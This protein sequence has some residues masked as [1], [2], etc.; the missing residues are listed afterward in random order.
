V[1]LAV[2]DSVVRLTMALARKRGLR[3]VAF[4]DAQIVGTMLSHGIGTPVHGQR[5]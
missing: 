2:H 1:K 5:R 3:G 4:F